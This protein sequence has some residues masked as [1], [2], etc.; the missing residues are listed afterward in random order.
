MNI[1]NHVYVRAIVTPELI[2]LAERVGVV[3][4]AAK[5][6]PNHRWHH[7][8]LRLADMTLMAN[9]FPVQHECVY[10]P[11][12]IFIAIFE[13]PTHSERIDLIKIFS[14]PNPDL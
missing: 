2:N 7:L 6:V 4:N 13:L 11:A 5:N 9:F 14:I 12:H 1:R 8:R 10:V 3:N